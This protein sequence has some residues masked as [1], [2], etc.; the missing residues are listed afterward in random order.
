MEPTFDPRKFRELVLYI[1]ERSTDDRKFGTGKLYKILFFSDL[2]AFGILSRAITGAN[3]HRLDHG[4]AP[5][6]GDDVLR[7]M[8]AEGEIERTK[9]R[10]LNHPLMKVRPLRSPDHSLFSDEEIEIVDAIVEELRYVAARYSPELSHLE[11]AW[12]FA[13]DHQVIPYGVVYI[14]DRKPTPR[15]FEMWRDAMEEW[16]ARRAAE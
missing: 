15:E 3:Y 5:I 10:Y 9:A 13:G 7:E 14:S 16:R 11:R 4:P 1:A 8:E 12:E 6:E 2:K